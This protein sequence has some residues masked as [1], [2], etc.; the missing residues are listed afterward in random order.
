MS[1]VDIRAS[2]S[3]AVS[4]GLRVICGR[5]SAVALER[6]RLKA[7]VPDVVYRNRV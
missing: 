5:L 4:A 1:L 6:R 3:I 7:L 2:A